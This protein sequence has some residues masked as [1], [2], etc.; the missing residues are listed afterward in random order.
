MALSKG[1]ATPRRDGTFAEFDVEANTTIHAGGM[2]SLNAAGNAVPA[3]KDAAQK[4]VV[5]AAEN[6]A[7]NTASGNA[8]GDVKVRVR[9]GVFRWANLAT[10][11]VTKAHVHHLAYA[12]DDETVANVGTGN[13]PKVGLILQVEDAGVWVETGMEDRT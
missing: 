7:A 11:E 2:V 10:A 5:G 3:S 1:R 12:D 8:A 13:R 4:A 6:D 9:R